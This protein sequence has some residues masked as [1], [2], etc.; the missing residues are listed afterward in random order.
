MAKT[1]AEVSLNVP[2]LTYLSLQRVHVTIYGKIPH[3]QE[4]FPWQYDEDE[5][6]A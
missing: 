2:V 6:A 1:L 4:W 5:Y 3:L